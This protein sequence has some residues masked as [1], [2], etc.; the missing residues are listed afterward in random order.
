MKYKIGDK[1]KRRI[2]MGIFETGEIIAIAPDGDYLLRVEGHSD[3]LKGD[4]LES[5]VIVKRNSYDLDYRYNLVP[6][7][8]EMGKT[9]RWKEEDTT[10]CDFEIHRTDLTNAT[11]NHPDNA[12]Q[13][14]AR[15]I[16][17]TGESHYVLL[18]EF[19]FKM[20]EEVK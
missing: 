11:P 12:R 16:Y 20:M 4:M 9:Y 17:P 2:G 6:D 15:K 3:H 5:D 8:F 19:S 18:S 13:A 1:F 14:L 10:A 7:F